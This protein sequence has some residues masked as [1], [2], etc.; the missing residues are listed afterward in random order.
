MASGE[1]RQAGQIHRLTRSVFDDLVRRHT[2]AVMHQQEA[3]VVGAYGYPFGA[4][5]PVDFA[6]TQPPGGHAP[7]GCA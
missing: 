3:S 2:E 6:V 7:L 1:R 5:R 4:V